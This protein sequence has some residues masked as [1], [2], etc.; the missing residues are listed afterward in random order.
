MGT[1][2]INYDALATQHGASQDYDALAERHGGAT[3]SRQLPSVAEQIGTSIKNQGKGLFEMLAG[4]G[5]AHLGMKIGDAAIDAQ[6]DQWH[7]AKAEYAKGNYA[8]AARRGLAAV[9]PFLGPMIE[10]TAQKLTTPGQ[11]AEGVT[12]VALTPILAELAPGIARGVAPLIERG[13]MGTARA[14]MRPSLKPGVSD[15]GTLADVR[16]VTDTA[17]QHNIPVTE[18][19]AQKLQDLIAE[20]G[21][22]IQGVVDKKTAQGATVDPNAVAARADQVDTTQV[23]PEKD[24][25][26]VNKAKEA[27]LARKGAKPAQPTG[28]LDAKGNPIMAQPTPAQPV[29]FDVAQA[30]KQGTYVHNKAQYG[31][32]AHAQVEAEKALARGYKEEMETQ[33]PELKLLNEQEGKFLNLQGVLER[34]VRN[35]GNSDIVGLKDVGVAATGMAAAGPAGATIGIGS[36]ILRY[37]GVQSR[38]AIAINKASQKAGNQLSISASQAKASAILARIGALTQSQ[39]DASGQ[40]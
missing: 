9:T 27:F 18:A 39:S 12:D 26:T 10:N 38:L 29:P 7:Q 16:Q 8:N 30:E 5:D 13:G 24:A 22:K 23:L 15:A 40:P 4:I 28:L 17:L 34:A 2:P 35:A 21:K 11:R 3:E 33:A 19:G 1:T 31:E 37:P 32:K 14:L 36:R 25:A 6:V 20:Y